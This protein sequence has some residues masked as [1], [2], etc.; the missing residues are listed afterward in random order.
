[1]TQAPFSPR[2]ASLAPLAPR[3]GR[4]VGSEGQTRQASQPHPHINGSLAGGS[5]AA[6][7]F[8]LFAQEKVTKE[9]GTP[10][11]WPSASRS[12]QP[13]VGQCGN[14]L[15]FNFFGS[16]AQTSALLLT[17]L[18]L[19][20]AAA[21]EGEVQRQSQNRNPGLPRP[22]GP[23]NDALAAV[24]S[25]RAARSN[26][27]ESGAAPLQVLNF[28]SPLCRRGRR[29]E[30]GD[31]EA[32]VF[33]HV[34]AKQIVRVCEPPNSGLRPRLAPPCFLA[35]RHSGA[36]PEGGRGAPRSGDLTLEADAGPAAPASG[37]DSRTVASRKRA[38]APCS[39]GPFSLVTFLLA[40]QK[41][42]TCR[43]ATPGKNLHQA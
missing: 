40:K 1:M 8:L 33:E 22:C 12:R 42:V 3:A 18:S 39:Q 4:G 35:V 38:P 26:P 21:S 29:D 7:D 37:P 15:R 13:Q 28:L 14:S 17:T 27:V 11:R 5:P 23:R 41:K 31:V 6:S 34:A 2:P 32:S 19:P 10:L 24:T 36:T 9:K 16:E 20:S 30:L 43:R 25:L